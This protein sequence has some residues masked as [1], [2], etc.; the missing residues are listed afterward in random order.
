MANLFSF[1]SG[2]CSL[3]VS[4]EGTELFYEVRVEGGVRLY[5]CTDLREAIWLLQATPAMLPGLADW[6]EAGHEDA[7]T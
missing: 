1:D 4:R 7:T 2:T 5:K 3:V 6:M